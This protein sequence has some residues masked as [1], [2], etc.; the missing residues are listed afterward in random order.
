MSEEAVL[1]SIYTPDLSSEM[2]RA[3]LC[4]MYT[5]QINVTWKLLQEINNAFKLIG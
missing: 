4:L 3:I 2:V 5:G 1:S